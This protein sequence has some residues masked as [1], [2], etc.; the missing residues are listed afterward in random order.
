MDRLGRCSVTREPLPIPGHDVAPRARSL[1][2]SASCCGARLARRSAKWMR[3]V[4]AN[5]RR[6]DRRFVGRGVALVVRAAMTIRMVTGAGGLKGRGDSSME[7]ERVLGNLVRRLVLSRRPETLRVPYDSGF[8]AA[9]HRVIAS[10]SIESEGRPV[11]GDR[12][13]FASCDG[14]DKGDRLGVP[15]RLASPRC[16]GS[17]GCEFGWRR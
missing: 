11:G 8:R 4:R 14:G 7:A 2:P 10:H 13:M 15:G 17:G 12:G 5:T 1:P 3:A 9:H 6:L 16:R